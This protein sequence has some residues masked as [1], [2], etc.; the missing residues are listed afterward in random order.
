MARPLFDGRRDRV[1]QFHRVGTAEEVGGVKQVDV[2]GVALY[3]LSAVEEAAQ[4]GH[5]P[6]HLHTKSVLH[7]GAGAHLVRHRAYATDAGCDVGGLGGP[8]SLQER[9]E[10]AGR[11]EDVERHLSDHAVAD[12]HME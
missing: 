4:I 9:F 10:K 1:G 12:L 8:A 3:P 5:L 7:R 6:T 11:L 2:Q